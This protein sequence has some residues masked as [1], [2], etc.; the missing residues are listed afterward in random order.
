LFKTPHRLD[1]SHAA[2]LFGPEHRTVDG[3]E[4]VAAAYSEAL[5]SDD[6]GIVAVR[7]DAKASFEIRNRLE[8][9]LSDRWA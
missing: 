2:D 3:I 9:T 8:A 1:F 7:T 5:D 4:S 6:S